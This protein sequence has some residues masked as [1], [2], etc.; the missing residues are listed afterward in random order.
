MNSTTARGSVRN[1]LRWLAL[2]PASIGLVFL[3]VAVLWTELVQLVAAGALLAIA[4]A[5]WRTCDGSW[6]APFSRDARS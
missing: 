2:V 1:M 3:V 6:P 5:V 4:T